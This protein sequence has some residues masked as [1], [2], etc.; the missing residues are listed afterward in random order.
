MRSGSWRISCQKNRLLLLTSSYRFDKIATISNQIASALW[1]ARHRSPNEQPI[2]REHVRPGPNAHRPN[3]RH[4]PE[5][6][7]HWFPK[8]DNRCLQLTKARRAIEDAQT[9][10]SIVKHLREYEALKHQ[11]FHL[12]SDPGTQNTIESTL[13]HPHVFRNSCVF[14]QVTVFSTNT[15]C[16]DVLFHP[17]RILAQ[18][19]KNQHLREFSNIT[20]KVLQFCNYAPVWCGG[21][22][23]V[24]CQRRP[25]RAGW[26]FWRSSR[27]CASWTGGDRWRIA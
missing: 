2:R 4:L 22:K 10:R 25:S 21:D 12:P 23:E 6:G 5:K 1:N 7:K 9:A 16:S 14:I 11:L 13:P 26:R 20:N 17:Q 24:V 18:P 27:W 19:L 15:T 8:R 3:E